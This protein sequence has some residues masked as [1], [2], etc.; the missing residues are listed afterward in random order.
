MIGYRQQ[1]R[2][3]EFLLK[4]ALTLLLGQMLAQVFSPQPEML[5]VSYS[6]KLPKMGGYYHQMFK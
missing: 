1:F 5:A 6:S 2:S 4:V 3:G